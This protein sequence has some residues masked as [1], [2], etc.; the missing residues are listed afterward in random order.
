[1]LNSVY[2]LI[3]YHQK[4]YAMLSNIEWLYPQISL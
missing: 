1:M 4:A 2:H 3:Y